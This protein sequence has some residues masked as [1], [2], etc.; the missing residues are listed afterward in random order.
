M[1]EN[2]WSL[3]SQTGNIGV[4]LVYKNFLPTLDM[5]EGQSRKDTT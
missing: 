5:S 1:H 3:F 4:Y 2:F